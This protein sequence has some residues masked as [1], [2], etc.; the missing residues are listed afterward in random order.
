MFTSV[1]CAIVLTAQISAANANLS[2]TD[3]IQE[4]NLNSMADQ[5]VTQRAYKFRIY[6]S[7]VQKTK[8]EQT[9]SLCCELYNAALQERRDAWRINRTS[10]NYHAQAVQLPEIKTLRP[11]LGTVHSQILQDT[12]KR[13]DKAF[14]AFF[15]RLKTKEKAGFPRFRSR[16]RYDSFTFPQSGFAIQKGKL[17]LS[18]IGKVKIKLHR[19]IEGRIKTCTI[20][21][22]STGKWFACFAVEQ[23]RKPENQMGEAIGVDVGLKTF[24]TLSNGV[25]IDN[26][27]FFRVE[28]KR[29]VKAQKRLSKAIKGS[30]ERRKRRKIVAHVHERIAN[31]R[32]DFAHQVSCYLVGNFG[33]IVFENLNIR[34]MLKNHCLAKSIADAAWSQLVNYTAY[35][36]ENAGR[37]CIQVNPRNTSKMC[38]RCGE[39]VE[40]DLSVRIHKCEGCGL[41]LDRDHN[42]AIN[43]LTLGLQSLGQQTIEAASL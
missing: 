25:E 4:V 40:K 39:L 29:L 27:R 30:P 8:L 9:L 31:K 38:S 20:T 37:K 33:V 3:D 42:A 36:A 43:I 12:L 26:P 19:D 10:I 11:E 1:L 7:R 35:K 32:K 21:R 16:F 41:T 34:G 5:I 15:R 17:S 13:L 14:D 22:T 28:E 23:T 18:K 2:L 6:P 24:T